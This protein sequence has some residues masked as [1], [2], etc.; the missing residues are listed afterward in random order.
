MSAMTAPGWS[1]PCAHNPVRRT[2]PHRGKTCNPPPE[3]VAPKPGDPCPVCRRNGANYGTIACKGEHLQ[4]ALAKHKLD[5]ENWHK[6]WDEPSP[7]A[8]S[9]VA[10][11]EHQAVN[12]QSATHEGRIEW[13]RR[14]ERYEAT[15]TPRDWKNGKRL[16]PQEAY[17]GGTVAEVKLKLREHVAGVQFADE[18]E[19]V[20][21]SVEFRDAKTEPPRPVSKSR[22]DLPTRRAYELP[23]TA[24]G[25][26]L[27][28]LPEER[29]VPPGIV[30][31]KRWVPWDARWDQGKK[32]FNKPP[33]SCHTGKQTGPIAKNIA[34]F[35]TFAEARA[36]AEKFNCSGVGFV[37]LAGDGRV[38]IDFDHCISDDHAIDPAAWDWLGKWFAETYQEISPSGDGIHALCLGRMPGAKG[39]TAKQVPNA[40]EGVTSEGYDH[41]RFLTFT[42]QRT[43]RD[44]KPLHDCQ[45]SIDKLVSTLKGDSSSAPEDKPSAEGRPMSRLAAR[46]IH[47]DNLAALRGSKIG[48]RNG[49]ELLNTSA[50]FAGRAFAGGALDDET[51]E[52]LKK[53]LLGIVTKEWTQPHP[54]DGARATIAGGWQSGFAQPLPVEDKWPEVAKAVEELNNTFFAVRDFGTKFRVCRFVPVIL[55]REDR[56]DVRRVIVAQSRNDFYNGYC[57][58]LIKVGEKK[59]VP[60]LKDKATVWLHHPQRRGYERVVFKPEGTVR[61]DELNLWDDFAFPEKKGN[62]SLYLSHLRENIC[63]GNAAHYAWLARWMA[64]QV[65]NPGKVGESAVVIHGEKGV[66]KNVFAE[67]F[68]ELWGQHGLVITSE[69]RVTS[70]FNAHLRDKCCLVA[71]EAFFAG[72]QRQARQLKGLVTGGTLQIESKGVDTVTV[73]NLLRLIII[74]NDRHL[75]SA[76]GDERRFFVL[77]CGKKQQKNGAYFAAI[78]AELNA[79]GYSA[80]LYHLLHEVDLSGFDVRNPPHTDALNE[81]AARSTVGAMDVV[82]ECL[83]TGAIPGKVQKDGTVW[84]SLNELALWANERRS[85]EWGRVKFN[86]LRD[87]L[88]ARGL[89]LEPNKDRG[90]LS[91]KKQPRQWSVPQLRVCRRLWDETF[92]PIDWP[93]DD[94]EWGEFESGE[95]QY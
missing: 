91:G 85:T 71:D 37:L 95:R 39:M 24:D 9:P 2:C 8:S 78:N 94:G 66:G 36:A 17:T 33:R 82:R 55:P 45:V 16:P 67:G 29:D 92:F 19:R 46:K 51:E 43:T 10:M 4:R 31:Q 86:G 12:F 26:T 90:T 58:Q 20:D 60:E 13:D 89:K 93:E 22:P 6:T 27:L 41:D 44:V 79:G 59:G 65:R 64:W 87:V 28:V 57:N 21:A 69:S 70:N 7:A 88:G 56:Q 62:C 72:D 80:L 25:D 48:D 32:K 15:A 49:N 76:S 14:L 63:Q 30:D 34:E 53:L 81:Q 52:S 1:L 3:P 38:G 74:G 18:P 35:G 54:E 42:G 84:V 77:E 50:F 83:T 40:A 11:A 68:C 61:A 73:P 5:S 47:A 75:V 23:K